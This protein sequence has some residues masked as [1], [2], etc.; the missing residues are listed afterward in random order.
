MVRSDPQ[1]VDLGFGGSVFAEPAILIRPD[2]VATS[3]MT[4]KF[5]VLLSPPHPFPS[6]GLANE[7]WGRID[8]VAVLP[9]TRLSYVAVI[10]FPINPMGGLMC[11]F[12]CYL[13]MT[14]TSIP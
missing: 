2:L 14:A 5:C 3:M 8:E 13:S 10:D 1:I 4:P 6:S 7:S 12:P 9:V 11:G